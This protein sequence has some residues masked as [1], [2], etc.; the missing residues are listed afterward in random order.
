MHVASWLTGVGMHSI[1]GGDS[2]A[3][4]ERLQDQ[5]RALQAEL[6]G[7]A[8]AGDAAR[9]ARPRRESRR[10]VPGGG[11]QEAFTMGNVSKGF[12]RLESSFMVLEVMFL[13]V[14]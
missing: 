11:A 3:Q 14:C 4:V 7:A 1:Q 8:D 12:Q 2:L 5:V 6:A 13:K 9:C 10:S